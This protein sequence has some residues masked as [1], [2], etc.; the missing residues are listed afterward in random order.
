M[1]YRRGYLLETISSLQQH[2]MNL[3]IFQPNQCKYGYDSSPACNTFQLGQMIRFFSRS[4]TLSLQSAFWPSSMS[5]IMRGN[6][7]EL[8]LT[9]R[10][11]PGY[12]IN[13]FHVHC[14]IRTRFLSCLELII[15]LAQVGIGAQAESWESSPH[16]GTW[17]YA[18]R[19][20]ENS[21]V[22][23]DVHR[24]VKAMYTAEKRDW[25]FRP[26]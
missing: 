1:S 22:G 6:I 3:Y 17:R 16:G 10:A 26:P 12:Q 15:P 4:N 20:L 7:L 11:C 24:Q 9:L 25:T 18:P 13:S 2:F 19:A 23:C 5:Q 14:G 8:L 21:A